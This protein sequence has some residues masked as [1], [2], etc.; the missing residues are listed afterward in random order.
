MSNILVVIPDEPRRIAVKASLTRVGHCV[1]A[2][3]DAEEGLSLAAQHLPRVIL[4]D[5]SLRDVS[6]YHLFKILRNTPPHHQSWMVAV[7]AHTPDPD[8][9]D[10]AGI[11]AS[12]NLDCSPEDLVQH[13]IQ[14]PG[15]PLAI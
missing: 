10:D 8:Q 2:A 14:I 15:S 13:L 7:G 5:M 4:V 11:N 9:Y 3:A 12:I 6:G 1:H